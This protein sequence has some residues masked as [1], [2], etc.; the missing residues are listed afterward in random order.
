MVVTKNTTPTTALAHV[1]SEVLGEQPRESDILNGPYTK[2]FDAIGI[3]DIN[4]LLAIDPMVDFNDITIREVV[5]STPVKGTGLG[6]PSPVPGSRNVPSPPPP[7]TRQRHLSVVE[8]RTVLQLQLWFREFSVRNQNVPP[9]RRWFSL[10]SASFATWR[11]TYSPQAASNTGG[12]IPTG[13]NTVTTALETYQKGIK[14]DVGEYKHLKEDKFWLNFR[15]QL[16]LT[17]LTQ[18]VGRI[19]DLSFDPTTLTGEDVTLYQEQNTFCYK[20]LSTIVQTSTGRTYL[21]QHAEDHDA[22]AVFRAMTAY[23]TLSRVADSAVTT[24]KSSI[25]D[26]RFDSN[27][28]SGAVAFLN[29]WKTMVMDL[30]EVQEKPSDPMKRNVV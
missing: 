22:N 10:T 17:A 11:S 6:P 3:Q 2:A 24:L 13:R 14:R 30:D 23:Y 5:L 12:T 27:W 20:V 1:L 29:K 19:F 26:F 8:K 9:V 21:R 28:T 4:D 7:P 15:R 25:M 18:G 16:L